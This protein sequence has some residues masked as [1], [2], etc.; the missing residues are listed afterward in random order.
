MPL[1]ADDPGRE[2]SLEEMALALMA[3]V[4][5]LGVRPIEPSHPVGEVL[6]SGPQDEVV[7]GAHQ[8][9][10]GA[11]PA[12][13]AAGSIQQAEEVEPVEIVFEEVDPARPARRDV[14]DAVLQTRAGHSRHSERR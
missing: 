12:E 4:E 3:A 10:R 2:A 9:I 6:A 5:A 8:A 11:Q 1:V 14:V 7:M 13:V